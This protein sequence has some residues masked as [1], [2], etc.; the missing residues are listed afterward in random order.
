MKLT[1]IDQLK[2][3]KP[4]DTLFLI[5]CFGW[6]DQ[7]KVEVQ[8]FLVIQ[9]N[10]D[11]YSGCSQSQISGG[12]WASDQCFTDLLMDCKYAYTELVEA[13]SMLLDVRA[14]LHADK[15]KAHADLV[16]GEHRPFL[17]PYG[18][19]T[20]QHLPN[21][22]YLGD[23]RKEYQLKSVQPAATEDTIME[24]LKYGRV[25]SFK[26]QSDGTFRVQEKCDRH[27]DE[28]LTRDEMLQLAR[29]IVDMTQ[30]NKLQPARGKRP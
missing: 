16:L 18:Q 9:V 13:E 28:Y 7:E 21:G 8:R 26:P 27:F 24:R 29:E 25:V 4:G 1:T 17:P 23:W 19:L 20:Y 30:T 15:V 3:V 22:D 14:G 6:R 11:F 5:N 10:E 12:L 2:E